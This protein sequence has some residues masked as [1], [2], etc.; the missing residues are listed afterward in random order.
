MAGRVMMRVEKS[1]RSRLTFRRF[2]T[3]SSSSATRI[4]SWSWPPR[5]L[6]GRTGSR[7]ACGSRTGRVLGAAPARP[8]A[9]AHLLHRAA[10]HRVQLLCPLQVAGLRALQHRRGRVAPSERGQRPCR[11][12]A[13]LTPAG[14]GDAEVCGKDR[15]TPGWGARRLY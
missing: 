8:V 12:G 3:S 9:P 4:R 2:R 1:N 13:F 6:W 7:V 11:G 10:H 15:Q 5:T 14:R